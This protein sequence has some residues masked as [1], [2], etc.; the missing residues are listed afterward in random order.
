[1][2][3]DNRAKRDLSIDGVKFA[4]LWLVVL[5]HVLLFYDPACPSLFN[6]VPVAVPGAGPIARAIYSFHMPLFFMLA[7]MV[8]RPGK[9]C[10]A[11]IWKKVKRLLLP[12]MAVFIGFMIPTLLYLGYYTPLTWRDF[13]FNYNLRHVWYA[14]ALF[15]IFVLNR[16]CDALHMPKWL[17]LL[18]AG[19]VF[20]THPALPINCLGP[21]IIYF[22]I[23]E[24][25]G[26]RFNC[27]PAIWLTAG[28]AFALA[29]YTAGGREW[30]PVVQDFYVLGLA[31]TGGLFFYNLAKYIHYHSKEQLGVYLLHPMIIYLIHHA[32][33]AYHLPS[34]PLI[35][36]V[37]GVSFALSMAL[38]RLYHLLVRDRLIPAAKSLLAGGVGR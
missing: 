33:Q 22:Q 2:S 17:K 34:W 21:N 35:I 3:L 38:T 5:G 37:T 36:G 15:C 20:F 4:T 25:F 14:H 24:V 8:Y 29:F 26:K 12:S 16:L 31:V 19:L 23:G 32:L 1:M 18:A 9:G 28:L 27:R 11:F 13:A 6:M 7:G 10:G 30:P